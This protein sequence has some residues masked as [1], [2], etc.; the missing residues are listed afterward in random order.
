MTADLEKLARRATACPKW[1]WDNGMYFLNPD[2]GC[3]LRERSGFSWDALSPESLPDLTDPATLG[4]LT[5][6][7][8]EVWGN[9]RLHVVTDNEGSFVDPANGPY[10]RIHTANHCFTG[11]T[12]AEAL[13]AAL[14]GAS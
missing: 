3:R 11:E 13:V 14:E 1:E 12:E 2:Y 4:C 10:W 9:P 8:R 7:V 6:R 5:A